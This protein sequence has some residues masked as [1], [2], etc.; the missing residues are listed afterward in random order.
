MLWYTHNNNEQL[1][2]CLNRGA[3]HANDKP[4]QEF[5]RD[6]RRACD[7]MSLLCFL[8]WG[9]SHAMWRLSSSEASSFGGDDSGSSSTEGGT[10]GD[11][12]PAWIWMDISMAW[13]LSPITG[14]G[15]ELSLWWSIVPSWLCVSLAVGYTLRAEEVRI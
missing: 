4:A 13:V 10:E 14:A 2:G 6:A 8:F 3:K 1:F 11:P 15:L 9:F 7:G 12:L 5:E